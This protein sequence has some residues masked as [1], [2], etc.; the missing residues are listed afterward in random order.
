MQLT[1]DTNCLSWILLPPP[2][3]VVCL[4]PAVQEVGQPIVRCKSH[5]DGV[6]ANAVRYG[7][8]RGEWFLNAVSTKVV[9]LRR[10]D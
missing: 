3:W 5:A 9:L 1:Q 10:G 6:I 4:A 2:R 8:A 7:T